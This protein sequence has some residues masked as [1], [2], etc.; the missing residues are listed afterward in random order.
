MCSTARKYRIRNSAPLKLI[1]RS[2]SPATLETGSD[3]IKIC[4]RHSSAEFSKAIRCSAGFLRNSNSGYKT[5]CCVF[6]AY[7]RSSR[8][9]Y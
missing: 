1:L 5:N 7:R 3:A 9:A 2:I 8:N 4:L 6:Q